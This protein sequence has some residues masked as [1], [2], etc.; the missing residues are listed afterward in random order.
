MIKTHQKHLNRLPKKFCENLITNGYLIRPIKN[1]V[2]LREQNIQL[3]YCQ[4]FELLIH[5]GKF[6][7]LCSDNIGSA[8]QLAAKLR[9]FKVGVLKKKSATL[10]ITAK[11]SASRFSPGSNL[12]GVESF[13]MFERH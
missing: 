6:K 3:K 7:S 4:P 2:T 11:V 12:P 5:F 10:A 1:K 9:A 13:S 8:G